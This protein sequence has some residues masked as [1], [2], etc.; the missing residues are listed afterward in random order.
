MHEGPHTSLSCTIE[1]SP[2]SKLS[3]MTVFTL[4]KWCK[5]S[6]YYRRQTAIDI[7]SI[8]L[9][10]RY[11]ML[12]YTF[13]FMILRKYSCCNWQYTPTY[14]QSS[15]PLCLASRSGPNNAHKSCPINFF[16]R[17]DSL[18]NIPLLGADA[19]RCN[20]SSSRVRSRNQN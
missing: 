10:T 5:I 1:L 15:F 20:I 17:S 2:Q 12:G 16:I 6:F 14:I 3:L 11:T 8:G 9:I 18:A 4:P 13:D 19:G 7:R